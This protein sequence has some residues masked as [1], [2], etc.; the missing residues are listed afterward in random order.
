MMNSMKVVSVPASVP[1]T[2]GA[3]PVSGVALELLAGELPPLQA[4]EELAARVLQVQGRNAILDL[5]GA[6]VLAQGLPGLKPGTEI[7]LKLAGPLPQIRSGLPALQLGQEVSA[8]VLAQ[9]S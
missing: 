9:G 2:Q 8:K 5:Q 1:E 4:G 7:L 3:V 6:R